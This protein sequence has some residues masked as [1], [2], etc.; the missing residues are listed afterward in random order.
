MLALPL[1]LN[2][3]DVIL[4]QEEDISDQGLKNLSQIFPIIKSGHFV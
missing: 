2:R 3:L 1:D 4:D